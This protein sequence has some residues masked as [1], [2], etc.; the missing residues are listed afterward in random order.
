[1]WQVVANKG[2]KISIF[3]VWVSWSSSAPSTFWERNNTQI[4]IRG[5]VHTSRS[6]G[7]SPSFLQNLLFQ[8]LCCYLGFQDSSHAPL[9]RFLEGVDFASLAFLVRSPEYLDFLL[10]LPDGGQLCLDTPQYVFQLRVAH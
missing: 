6:Y 10:L 4:R 1:M 7:A 5:L 8:P 9:P 3:M 2:G